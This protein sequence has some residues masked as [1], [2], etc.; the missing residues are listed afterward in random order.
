[1]SPR[2]RALPQWRRDAVGDILRTLAA[3]G[4][5]EETAGGTFVG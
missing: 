1:M 2:R 4:Q 5:A 3:L